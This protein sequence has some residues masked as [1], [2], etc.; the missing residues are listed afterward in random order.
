MK[1]NTTRGRLLASTMI[2]S[3]MAAV[4]TTAAAQDQTTGTPATVQEI[5]VTG[6]RI[7]Q[8]NMTSVSPIQTVGRDEVTLSGH[9]QTIDILNQLPQVTQTSVDLGPTSDALSGPGGVSTA[10]LRGLGPQHT[11]VLVDGRRLGL[12]DPNTGNPNPAPDIN[13]I[14]SQLI[15][16]VE[17]LTGGASATYGSDAIG[18]VVNFIMRDDFE[19]VEVDAQYGIFQ[20]SQQS[21]TMKRV[22]REGNQ[23]VPG[24]VWDGRSQDYSVILGANAPDGRGNVTAFFT[25]SKQAPVKQGARDYSACQ[26]KVASGGALVCSGSSN[27]NI[28]YPANGDLL[29]LNGNGI[30]ANDADAAAVLGHEFVPYGTPGTTPPA[31]FNA[32]PY[33]YL[34]QDNSRYT[35]GYFAHYEV[36]E[37]ADFYSQFNFM[38]SETNVN[39]GPSA[40]F[41]GSGVT[42]SGGF[43]LNC[44]NPLLSAQQQTALAA[45]CTGP[46]VDGHPTADMYFGRRN[47]EGGPRNSFYDHTNYRVVFGARGELVGPWRYDIYGSFYKTT[48]NARVENYLSLQRIQDALLVGGTAANP[49]CLSGNAGCVPYN[50][51]SDGGVSQA[52]ASTLTILG[53]Q[54]GSTT[55]R[56]IEGTLTGNLGD[57]GVKSPW[58]TDGVG[59][60]LG[61]TT[62]RDHLRYAPDAASESGDLSGS[63][64]ASV[65][66]NNALGVAELF[67][68]L[69]VPLVSDMPFI[70]D[71][72]LETGYRWSDYS[73]GINASTYKVGFQWQPVEDIRFR[74]SYNQ[75]IRAP[76]ILELYTPQSVTNTSDVPED[77]CAK[78][79]APA[80]RPTEAQCANTGVTHDQYVNQSIPQCP[81]NQCAVFTGGNTNLKE[82]TAKTFTVGFTTRPSFLTGFTGSVDY[83]RIRIDDIIGTIPLDIILAN[84]LETGNPVYCSQVIRNPS[85]GILFGTTA[86]AGGYINGTNVNVA[87]STN[88]GFD[89]Q[90]S[91]KLPLETWG[92]DRYGGVSFTFNGSLLTKQANV[93]LPG[94]P[95]YDCAGYFGSTCGSVYPKWRHS[96]RVNWKMPMVDATLSAGWRHWGE[97]K[98]EN[99]SSDVG[100]NGP[101]DLF[102]RKVDSRDYFDLSGLWNV[103]DNFTLR[104]GV[105]NVFDQDPPL[106]PNA[107]VGGALPNSYPLYDLLGRKFFMGITAK[108]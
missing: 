55:E 89:F 64:G 67:G 56:I 12:G 86:G 61:F 53:T 80:D 13:Q 19:G 106:V 98:Y 57:Y 16:R 20:H 75:A 18:G 107:I 8:P 58:A 94:L 78:N 92:M 46:L 88:E 28:L 30:D 14:P 35:A 3:A 47:I 42:A 7:A 71:L 104:G 101:P 52:A 87:S 59:V 34:I 15:E 23:P 9:P 4:A 74:G 22:L 73:T 95:A 44:D 82:E 68:E 62:R 6:S 1:I 102:I 10:D 76:N 69:R 29:D 17:V 25:Y 65:K 33:E 38:Q 91:Y 32:N 79:I 77:P 45:S 11:L 50:I 41:Q 21:D 24:D 39:I 85:N 96:L 37:H 60:A 2:C 97:A 51:F 103:N 84:C 83:Y 99:L 100:L 90:A 26:L 27:S 93:S 81:A 48:L 40:L 31:I 70:Q 66:I 43:L 108:F 36:N 54:S 72:V 105:N 5:V 63:G 49:V